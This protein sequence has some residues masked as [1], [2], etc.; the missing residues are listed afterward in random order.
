MKFYLLSTLYVLILGCKSDTTPDPDRIDDSEV[1]SSELVLSAN[2]VFF[3][4]T[5]TLRCAEDKSKAGNDFNKGRFFTHIESWRNE[6]DTIIWGVKF[7]NTGKI[8]ITP[9]MEVANVQNKSKV[10]IAI[11]DVLRTFSIHNKGQAESFLNQESV[12]FNIEKSGSYMIKLWINKRNDN[13]EIGLLKECKLEGEAVV[14]AVVWQRR[15]RPLAVHCQW[16]NSSEPDI[17][18]LAVHENTIV[19]TDISCYQPIT[20]PFGYFGSSWNPKL[21]SF[22]GLNFSLWSFKKDDAPP[23]IEE[24][25]HLIAVGKGLTFGGYSH[26]GTGV[27]P[28]GNNPFDGVKSNRQVIAVRKVPGEKYDTYYS[29]YLD[30]DNSK[31]VLFASGKKYNKSGKLKYLSTGAF[32]EQPGAPD[33]ERS[34]PYYQG[35]QLSRMADE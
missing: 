24:L 23:P 22:G 1:K 32:I 13:K 33:K 19:T 12:E 9:V 14:N 16:R 11:D 2:E 21:G 5:G 15:W 6:T 26:E 10:N 28:R 4:P 25:S 3:S 18:S 29:H 20:T 30:L 17:I 7:L 31:W 35:S 27:K 8:K 34:G